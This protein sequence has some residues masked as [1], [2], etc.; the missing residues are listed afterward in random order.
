MA[1]SENYTEIEI[2]DIKQID[3]NDDGKNQ[4]WKIINQIAYGHINSKLLE[5]Q[6]EKI[7]QF[8]KGNIH[9]Q[10]AGAAAPVFHSCTKFIGQNV[11]RGEAGV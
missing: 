10:R 5:Q 8:G 2:K 9:A 3:C 11:G 1:E 7:R 4:R 6:L